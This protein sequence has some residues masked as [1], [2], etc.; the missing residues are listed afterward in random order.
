MPAS[1]AWIACA[2]VIAGPTRHVRGAG[3]DLEIPQGGMPRERRGHPEVRDHDA[4]GR[5]AG[6]H[7]DRRAAAEEVLH[8]LRGHDLRIG[9]HALRDHAVIAREREDHRVPER[10]ADTCR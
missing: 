2:R 9:A 5:V 1:I 10:R 3:R 4:R 8:H 6:E 7:V